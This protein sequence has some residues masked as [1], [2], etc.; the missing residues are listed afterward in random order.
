MNKTKIYQVLKKFNSHEINRL[1]KFIISPFFN[2]NEKVSHLFQTLYNHFKFS[3]PKE[4]EKDQIWSK[5]YKK[6]YDD[7]KFRKL[8]SDLLKLVERYFTQIAFE[9]SPEEQN[10]FLIQE[11]IKRNEEKLFSTA[12]SRSKV[13]L[14]RTNERSSS[15]F[16]NQYK[17]GANKFSLSTEFDL[18]TQKTKDG[19]GTNIEEISRNL[20]NF[21]LIEKLKYYLSAN[22]IKKIRNENHEFALI[23]EITQYLGS[24]D[25][26]KE[27]ALKLYYQTYL[28]FTS[29]QD[30]YHYELLKQ[31]I[32]ENLNVLGRDEGRDIFEAALNF[33]IRRVN[34]G[35]SKF[36]K[37]ALDLYKY[38]LNSKIMFSKEDELSPTT[39]RNIVIFAVRESEFNWAEEFINKYAQYLPEKYR[40]NAINY[41]SA[42]IQ[43]YRKQ[44]DKVIELIRDVEYQDLTYNLNSKFML[45]AS[46]YELKEYDS[47]FYFIN[48]YKAF[49]RRNKSINPKRKASYMN[50]VNIINK[51]ANLESGDK[52]QI[53]K[54]QLEIN[55]SEAILSKKW[56]LEKVD[57]LLK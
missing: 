53:R 46:Y 25:L 33:C 21:Y 5:L 3:N 13:Q 42:R 57:E 32:F 54:I 30:D 48:S 39:F 47:L 23:P 37:E 20:D 43:W 24:A 15:F 55:E 8:C 12:L 14:S 41:N 50:F 49:L 16:Y 56:L 44:F 1:E 19:M 36:H 2:S 27:P 38:S 4:L 17:L 26:S 40:D 9:A 45:L 31:L 11:L 28:A 10:Q 6:P 22:T 35:N 52:P 29:D 18:K 7:V 34:Q 51:L